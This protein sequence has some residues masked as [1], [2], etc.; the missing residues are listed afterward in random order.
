MQVLGPADAGVPWSSLLSPTLRPWAQTSRFLPVVQAHRILT[1]WNQTL[2][3]EDAP[4]L[5][6]LTPDW[7][8]Q[9]CV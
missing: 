6:Q 8:C 2:H 7:G 9:A 1:P 4:W 5:G 3:I